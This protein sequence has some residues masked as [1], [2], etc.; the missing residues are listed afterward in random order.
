M[1]ELDLQTLNKI[2]DQAIS[3]VSK[4]KEDIFS[5][6]EEA[7]TELQRL[8]KQLEELR[9][10]ANKTRLEVDRAEKKARAA[11]N[12]LA[13]VSR[14][15]N[16]YSEEQ[17]KRAYEEANSFQLEL[18]LLRQREAELRK[19]RDAT[20]R[21]I[22]TI[23]RLVDRSE[24][25]LT[26]MD[27]AMKMLSGSWR[28]IDKKL[29]RQDDWH[30]FS[31]KI[32][33]AQEEERLRIARDLHDGPVQN[34]ASIAMR[35]ELCQRLLELAP[36]ELKGELSQLEH[37]A[38]DAAGE[39]RKMIFNLRPLALDDLG[40]VPALS[41]MFERLRKDNSFHVEF[42]V[43]GEER[44]LEGSKEVAIY[45]I[46]QEALNNVL[47]HAEVNSAIVKM[48]FLRNRLRVQII[49]YGCGFDIAQKTADG[50]HGLL[51][52][53]ERAELIGAELSIKTKPH[54]GTMVEVMLAE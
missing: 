21:N 40:L 46:I 16:K 52:M 5:L 7:S 42:V 33:L 38:K 13:Q 24:E 23:K 41:R 22:L 6:A 39:L 32:I 8:G 47:K 54:Q 50:Q 17:I 49:D 26:Q 2:V 11:R 36:E 14:E 51:I 19:S 12:Y 25:L 3:A 27:M 28:E 18:L 20:E 43:H 10:L 35:T 29:R 45:R 44:R 30:E 4:S 15:F 53:R 31:A 48:E 34:L 1:P 37:M 9:Q